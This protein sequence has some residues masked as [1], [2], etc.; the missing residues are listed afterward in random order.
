M[1]S[2]TATFRVNPQQAGTFHIKLQVNTGV[3]PSAPFD[4]VYLTGT[5][6][7]P[8]FSPAVAIPSDHTALLPQPALHSELL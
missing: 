8:T 7:D 2:S 3:A 1:N 5:V 4:T 6:Y